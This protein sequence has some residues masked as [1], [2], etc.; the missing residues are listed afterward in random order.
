MAGTMMAPEAT[1]MAPEAEITLNLEV[2]LGHCHM[3][4]PW[5]KKAMAHKEDEQ[6]CV[7]GHDDPPLSPDLSEL[8]VG[9][10]NWLDE[11]P[12][13]SWRSTGELLECSYQKIP[14][15]ERI[16]GAVVMDK[17]NL[18]ESGAMKVNIVMKSDDKH[19][20]I[21]AIGARLATHFMLET[22]TSGNVMLLHTDKGTGDRASEYD[23][24]FR[25]KK[26]RTFKLGL[27]KHGDTSNSGKDDLGIR[28]AWIQSHGWSPMGDED[29]E[30]A[31]L[32]CHLVWYTSWLF[33]S[34][35]SN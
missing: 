17:H 12:A 10:Q 5:S 33:G 25:D 7:W 19:A 27:T 8:G 34:A 30:I 13:A 20:N 24:I 31:N 6:A 9:M 26:L 18:K 3:R 15:A 1:M 22:G 35:G 28:H 23:I 11:Q 2:L 21:P 16:V 4:G 32:L 14:R 29:K